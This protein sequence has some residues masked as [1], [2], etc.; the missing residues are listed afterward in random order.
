MD[1]IFFTSDHHFYHKNIIKYSNRPFKSVVHMNEIMIQKWNEVVD[2]YSTVYYLGDLSLG[3]KKETRNIL[4]RLN[5]KIHLIWG[6]HERSAMENKWRFETI[7]GLSNISIKDDSIDK[8]YQQIILSHTSFQVWF[9]I[10]KGSWNLYGHSH[11]SL[12][13]RK[14]FKSCDIGVDSWDFYPVSY[15]Q[16]KTKFSK[17]FYKNYIPIDHHQ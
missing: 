13:E 6:N 16:L 1:K 2:E 8:G 4:E 9:G 17:D 5:G 10:H 7:K 15:K 14:G 12:K 11:G 3:D